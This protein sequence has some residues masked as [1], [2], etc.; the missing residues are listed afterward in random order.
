MFWKKKRTVEN[1]FRQHYGNALE[2]IEQSDLCDEI[3]NLP[4]EVASAMT[5]IS[6]FAAASA[7]KIESKFIQKL[8][9]GVYMMP[10]H[11]IFQCGKQE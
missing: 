4:F 3:E 6:D 11:K 8:Q 7:K 1:I 9:S 5:V 10:P 2:I